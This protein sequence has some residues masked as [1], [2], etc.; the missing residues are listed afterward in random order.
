MAVLEY[1]SKANPVFEMKSAT[2]CGMGYASVVLIYNGFLPISFIR[3]DGRQ[4]LMETE[5][6]ISQLYNAC[7]MLFG[8]EIDASVDFLRYLQIPGLKAVYRRKAL[9]T[10]PDRAIALARPV[11]ALEEQFK[12]ISAAYQELHDYLE[13]PLRFKLI[14]DGFRKKQNRP[15]QKMHTCYGTQSRKTDPKPE[16]HR[17][18]YYEGM[19]PKRG[20]LFG[21]Y[22]YY[23]G[24][25]SYRQLIDAIIWQK[26]QRPL[27]G[28][29]AVHWEWLYEDDVREILKQRLWGEKFGES[30]L[31]GG[32]LTPDELRIILGRQRLLQPRIGQYFVERRI[33]TGS[34]VEKMAERFRHHNRQYKSRKATTSPL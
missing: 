28:N 2:F 30:A 20:L 8:S 6:R 15:S 22:I 13:N 7:Q 5:L 24:H 10:H 3:F 12:Q 11:L 33:L 32:Y 25:I 21:Q 9:E 18:Q 4:G 23:Y 16:R 29:I 26:I 14:D 27:I 31:R 34:L 19:V 1:T 17:R